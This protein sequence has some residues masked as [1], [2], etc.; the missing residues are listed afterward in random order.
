MSNSKPYVDGFVIVIAKNRVEDY[1]Q[2]AARAGALWIE[3]G[4]LDYKECVLEDWSK[5][6]GLRSFPELA[7]AREDETV[8]FAYI[9]FE[10]REARD[11]VNAR[12]MADPRLAEICPGLQE[13]GD[14]PFDPARMAYGGFQTIVSH[15][16][17]GL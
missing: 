13:S 12:V 15:Q 9:V 17:G 3:H 2:V 11:A 6:E 4:A 16:K 14:M 1:R 8:V 5:K 10:S 7:G